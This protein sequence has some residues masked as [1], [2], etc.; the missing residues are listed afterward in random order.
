MSLSGDFKLSFIFLVSFIFPFY[1]E[2][3][4]LMKFSV[5]L[6]FLLVNPWHLEISGKSF[7]VLEACE[8]LGRLC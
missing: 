6:K 3:G 1:W 2:L 5:L 8:T 7:G 4:D